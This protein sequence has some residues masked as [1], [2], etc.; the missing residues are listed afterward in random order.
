MVKTHSAAILQ[1]SIN[2]I[3]EFRKYLEYISHGGYSLPH[4]TKTMELERGSEK[5]VHGIRNS[6]DQHWGGLGFWSAEGGLKE[7]F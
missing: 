3:P 5:V 1:P 4:R 6:V 2:D 7:C